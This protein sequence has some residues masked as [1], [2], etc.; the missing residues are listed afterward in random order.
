MVRHTHVKVILLPATSRKRVGVL[1]Q[2]VRS[3]PFPFSIRGHKRRSQSCA[4]C[5]LISCTI[6]Q[7]Q[8]CRCRVFLHFSY[9][10]FCPLTSCTCPTV[11][12]PPTFSPLRRISSYRL[13]PL[14][15][16]FLPPILLYQPF[17]S[18]LFNAVFETVARKWESNKIS[19]MENIRKWMNLD[20]YPL[21]SNDMNVYVHGYVGRERKVDRVK[22]KEDGRKGG[23]IDTFSRSFK[24]KGGVNV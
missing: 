9:P 8:Q 4:I 17:D 19:P 10:A 11:G 7:A 3:F 14:F 2:P 5:T 18:F 15:F 1:T 16:F 21:S 22:L 20:R 13:F 23:E 12:Y 6:R 24:K